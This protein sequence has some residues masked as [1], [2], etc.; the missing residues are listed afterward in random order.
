MKLLRIS[1]GGSGPPQTRKS[2]LMDFQVFLWPVHTEREFGEETNNTCR[3][4]GSKGSWMAQQITL[5]LR[6]DALVAF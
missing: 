2:V 1:P 5:T 4:S 3:N 6:T